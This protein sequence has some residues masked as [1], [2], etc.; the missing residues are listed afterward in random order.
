M[1]TLESYF[2]WNL[3]VARAGG[4]VRRVRVRDKEGESLFVLDGE[5]IGVANGESNA[6]DG[7][8][9]KISLR[10]WSMYCWTHGR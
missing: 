1:K 8:L 4:R 9:G 10:K 6:R 2:V 7:Y 5:S 3:R